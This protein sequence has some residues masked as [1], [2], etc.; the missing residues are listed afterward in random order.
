MSERDKESTLAEAA[1]PE[2]SIP[3]EA[4]MP[5]I[6]EQAAMPEQSISDEAGLFRD[7]VV[8]GLYAYRCRA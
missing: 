4:A 2:Q 3:E 1:M 5:A 6:P 7:S 8:V